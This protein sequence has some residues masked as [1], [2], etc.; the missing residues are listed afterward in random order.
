MRNQFIITHDQK[1]A[2]HDDESL[3]TNLDNKRDR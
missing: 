2:R 3:H 1:D